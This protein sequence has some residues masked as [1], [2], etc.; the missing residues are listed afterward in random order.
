MKKHLLLI[1]S[2]LLLASGCGK[3]ADYRQ[4]LSLWS[5]YEPAEKGGNNVN[6]YLLNILAGSLA[7][8][9]QRLREVREYIAWYFERMNYP[10][11][12][13]LTGTVYDYH[14]DL[15]GAEKPSGKYDSADSYAATFIMLLEKYSA[16]TGD[17]SLIKK[18]WEKV[19]DCVYVIIALQ[20]EDGLTR[21]VPYSDAK[22]LMDNCEAYGGILSYQ[23]LCAVLGKEREGYFDAAAAAIKDGI[24]ENFYDP[25]SGLYC[26]GISGGV[27]SGPGKDIYPDRLAQIFPYLFGISDDPALLK[28]LV[29]VPGNK[30]VDFPLEQ[31]IIIKDAVL[32][33]NLALAKEV[34]P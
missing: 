26:W 13:G 29:A 12:S 23:R 7:G 32:R 20:D 25:A 19:Q 2:A 34:K 22:Y 16:A 5:S 17:Y 8:D 9:G 24:Q 1:M 28:K 30:I 11:S 10:D 15:N 33:F 27:K 18:N 31:R 3:P 14:I 6:P 4:V 21:A